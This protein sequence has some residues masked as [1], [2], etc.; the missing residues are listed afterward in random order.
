MRTTITA[1]LGAA[2]A[3]LGACDSN[4]GTGTEEGPVLEVA[5]RG[6]D[7]P[8]VSLAPAGGGASFTHVTVRGAVEFRARVYVRSGGGEWL[9]LTDRFFQRAAVD[10]S[11]HGATQIFA[12]TRVAEGT[13]DRLRVAFRDVTADVTGGVGAAITGEVNVDLADGDSVVIEREMSAVTTSGFTTQIVLNLNSGTW[14]ALADPATRLV[15]PADF[16]SAVEV[17]VR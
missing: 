4:I 6:E 17:S 8:P 13:Y 3:A 5:A 9:E 2:L 7:P 16:A 11:G 10:A 12:G 15:D 1:L 14:L